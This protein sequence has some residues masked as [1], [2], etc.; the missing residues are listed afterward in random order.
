MEDKS[1][2]DKP[3][4]NAGIYKLFFIKKIISLIHHI[5]ISLQMSTKMS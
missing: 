3:V 5:Y 1:L 4:E 2:K